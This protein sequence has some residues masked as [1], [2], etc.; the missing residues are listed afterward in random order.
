MDAKY[1]VFGSEMSPYSIKVRAYCRYKGVP[2]VWIP[3]RPD[4]EAEFKQF[5]KLPL[6]PTVATPDGQGLQDSTP[7]MEYLDARFPKPTTHPEDPALDF[8]SVLV[9]EFGDEW[10]N[11]LMFHHRWWAEV[12]QMATASTLARSMAPSA[13]DDAIAGMASVV[14]ERMTSRGHFVGSS[15][16]T[17]PLIRKY[18][19][20]L[21]EVLQAHLD[22]RPYLFGSRPA[23]GD[24][25]LA[26]QLYEA[27]IDPTCGGIM[28]ARAGHVL[29][30][31]HRMLEPRNDGH[32]EDWGTLRGT[33]EPLI[34]IVGKY[35][36]PW[37]AANAAA[38]DEGRDSFTVALAGENYT[39]PPQKYHA[40]SLKA[41]K[42]K[43]A[44][45]KDKTA[46]DPIL[47]RNGCKRFI[48]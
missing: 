27:S 36:L 31:C 14:R 46:L 11:K 7:I 18:L 25:G 13:D 48:T 37:S 16:A 5:A 4:N 20:Q 9:E 22:T 30:W 6:V 43:Y 21:L 44:A 1:R 47:E 38:L 24:F 26:A 34:E 35:F 17:A 40:K 39:Q 42:A 32:F 33:L 12:D 28:R 2:Y 3:R 23:F 10:G 41:L 29:D 19:L 8:L 45:V 15:A